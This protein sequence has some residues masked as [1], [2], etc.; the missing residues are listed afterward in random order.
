MWRIHHSDHGLKHEYAAKFART[1]AGFFLYLSRGGGG[2]VFAIF[3]DSAGQFPA[4]TM[5]HESVS[6]HHEY[7]FFFVYNCCDSN[8]GKSYDVVLKAFTAGRL[9][10]NQSEPHP[11]IIV[12]HSFAMNF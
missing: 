11:G 1:P 4:K 9:Y 12:D 10:V 2:G 3:N 7:T 6:P 5:R 8:M